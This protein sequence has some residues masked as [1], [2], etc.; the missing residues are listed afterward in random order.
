MVVSDCAKVSVIGGGM[1]EVPGVMASFVEALAVN[2]IRILQTVDS[3]TSI[4]ALIRKADI[5]K[6]VTSLHGKF[7]LSD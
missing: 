6:A 2:D 7:N 4:S 5:Q 3:H 1:R